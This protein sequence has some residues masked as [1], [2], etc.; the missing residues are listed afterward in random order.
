MK[1]CPICNRTYT[2]DAQKFCTKDGTSLV[3]AQPT[4]GLGETVRL[5]SSELRNTQDDPEVTRFIPRDIASQPSGDFDPF[6][7]IMARP[8]EN[9]SDLSMTT[10]DLMP[11]SMPPTPR[12]ANIPQEQP[13]PSRPPQ[14][15]APV[16][17]PSQPL[18]D[19]PADIGQLTMASF[20]PPPAPPPSGQLSAMPAPAP[21]PPQVG[22][23]AA[24]APKKKSKLPL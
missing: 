14:P 15:P 12:P 4:G 7:T 10:G 20:A 11:A 17:S 5:D 3:A 18:P 8:P 1:R 22:V 16:S 21:M 9:T 23:P 24:A 2:N 13:P 19:S 6:K